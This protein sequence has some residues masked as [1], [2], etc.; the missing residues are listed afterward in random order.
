[1]FVLISAAMLVAASTIALF[2]PR[3]RGLA[4]EQI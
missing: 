2:G 3:T 4:L 1:V